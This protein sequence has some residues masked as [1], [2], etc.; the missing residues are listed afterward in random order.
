MF[1]LA[2]TLTVLA[3]PRGF[4]AAHSV[5]LV[6]QVD[7]RLPKWLVGEGD[8]KVL[9]ANAKELEAFFMSVGVKQPD[10]KKMVQ[11]SLQEQAEK[12]EAQ[13]FTTTRALI[14][15][16]GKQ[17]NVHYFDGEGRSLVVGLFS[18][19]TEAAQRYVLLGV[20]RIEERT[21]ESLV[22]SGRAASSM[23]VFLEK[24]DGAWFTGSLPKPPPPDCT[25]VIKN[26]LKAIF[27]AEKAYFAEKDAYSNSLTKIG[28]DARSLGI[29]S[30]KVSVAGNAP[31]Q[32]FT[33]QVGL[34]NGL[35]KMDDK[36]TLSV[37][38]DCTR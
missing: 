20:P 6:T 25:M 18:V 21:I 2:L 7:K 32:T 17:T 13:K 31:D 4:P 14:T 22:D 33:V 1:A 9:F 24:K 12:P 30:A 35:M 29:S 38:S 37:V 34:E 3:A 26:A 28:I 15:Y 16:A 19:G 36:G 11:D 5:E 8:R 27:T 23:L 10:V